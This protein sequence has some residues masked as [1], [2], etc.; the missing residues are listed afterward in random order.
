MKEKLIICIILLLFLVS[1]VNAITLTSI[2]LNPSVVEQFGSVTVSSVA[3]QDGVIDFNQSSEREAGLTV[4]LSSKVGAGI[5]YNNPNPIFLDSAEIYYS[6][7]AAPPRELS[8]L[9][10]DY[11]E[12]N[13]GEPTD[14]ILATSDITLCTETV[15]SGG[16]LINFSFPSSPLLEADTNFWFMLKD[17]VG[18]PVELN[19]TGDV[20]PG[21]VC[22]F[23]ISGNMLA[24][25]NCPTNECQVPS[26][27]NKVYVRGGSPAPID[28]IVK[29][30]NGNLL[31]LQCGTSSGNYDLCTS[32]FFSISNP[33][34]SFSAIQEPPSAT[35]F[36]NVFDQNAEESVEKSET[37]TIT[38]PPQSF[39]TFTPIQNIGSFSFGSVIINPLNL[40]G[41]I[42]FRVD[43]NSGSSQNV[44]YKIL[45]TL[46]DRRQYFVFTA[47]ENQFNQG[48]WVFDDSLT[49]NSPV[50]SKPI[51]KIWDDFADHYEHSFFDT[52]LPLET[53]YYRLVYNLPYKHY[54]SIRGSTEWFNQLMPTLISDVN[55]IAHDSYSVSTFSGIRSIFIENVPDIFEDETIA[56]E[57][58][59]TAWSDVNQTTINAGQTINGIDSTT[60][61]NLTGEPQRFSFSIDATDFDS[62][63]LLVSS[64]SSSST[65]FITDYAIVPRGYFTK[66]LELLKPN[67]DPLGLFLLNGFSKK[68]LREGAGFKI[69]TEAYDREGILET[70]RLESF[71]DSNAASNRVNSESHDVYFESGIEES[72]ITFDRI[73][74]PIIDLN[75]SAHNPATPRTAIIK[76]TLLDSN[77]TAVAIQSQFVT[78]LQ[79]PYFPSDL[80]INFFP[81]EKRRG[82][83]P[84]GILEIEINR[85][86]TLEAFDIRIYSDGNT[87][88]NPNF[89]E[90]IYK[91]SDFSCNTTLCR[92]NL[93]IDE[94]LFED[95]NLTTITIFSLLNTEYLDL[96]NNLTR[97]DRRILVTPIELTTAKIHQVNER[98]DRTYRNTEEIPLVLVVRDSE[99]DSLKT[100]LQTHIT[101]QNCDAATAGNCI[102]QTIQ[103][104]PTGFVFDDTFNINY[105][106]FR[107]LYVLDSGDLLPD[108]NYIGFRADVSDQ[109]GVRSNITPVLAD[110]C[111]DQSTSGG[112][113]SNALGFLLEFFIGCTEAQAEIVSTT[114]NTDQEVRILIDDDHSVTGPSQ[115]L[116]ACVAPDTSAVFGK[117]LEQDLLCFVWY[118]VAEKPIDNFRFRITNVF[119][120]VSKIGSD[121]QFLEFNVPYE[122][123]ANNDVQLLA[124]ELETNQ[125]T[126]IDTAGEFFF[127]GLRSLVVGSFEVYGLDDLGKF[128]LSEGLI[129]NIG[130]DFNFNQAFSPASVSGAIF[131]RIKGIPVINANDYKNHPALSDG[132]LTLDKRNFIQVLQEKNISF[133]R[134]TAEME[135]IISG[136]TNPIILKDELGT[137]VIDETPSKQTINKGNLDLNNT[138][139]YLV[140]PKILNFKLQHVMFFN[141]FSENDTKTTLMSI[142]VTVTQPLSNTIFEFIEELTNDPIG[143]STVFLFANIVILVI[144]F[145]LLIAG[146][147]AYSLW[148]KKRGR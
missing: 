17:D 14:T 74:Q 84:S 103:Y 60:Q 13:P 117:P 83:N 24:V 129:T 29:R 109:T 118:E 23:P 79:Y 70:L 141:N 100:K 108:G 41:E 145:G 93:F 130:A 5:L 110:K 12:L 140:I 45:N 54:F 33:S 53:K 92:L 15:I 131:Y 39:L 138:Q 8:F 4:S 85:P 3:R 51:Q 105:F 135:L 94:Y 75:G 76:A 132:F 50:D 90:T 88:T 139:K 46:M 26:D 31:K 62:Q 34:C 52:V 147:I 47:T 99:A 56:F 18:N 43:S 96:D 137:I 36:C 68:Y 22:A 66:R 71:L 16:K 97:V 126:T 144:I 67:G 55:S 119:S 134:R 61:K 87:V 121:K 49:F 120:D 116:F 63:L 107:H 7:C 25:R 2:T 73:F 112:F 104:R 11:N 142:A 20:C 98:S 123:I 69:T 48:N 128:L 82:K 133:P 19:V 136:F 86:E 21:G 35:I 10:L 80:L 59:F 42:I 146:G 102:D 115:V 148:V 64:H 30:S 40:G 1:S 127:E 143:T 32:E 28:F 89:R 113:F 111:K 77:G 114:V 101:L 91:D 38:A 125:N 95:V 57:F 106:F 124:K 27:V 78:F 122:L 58:Q 6:G 37:L 65:I 81:T 72:T 44:E 9:L